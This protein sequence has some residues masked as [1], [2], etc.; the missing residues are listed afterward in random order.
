MLMTDGNGAASRLPEDRLLDMP[1][2]SMIANE[3]HL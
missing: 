3:M 1:N 2:L